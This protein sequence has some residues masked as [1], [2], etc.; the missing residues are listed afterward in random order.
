MGGK[1]QGELVPGW[2]A[3]GMQFAPGDR[4]AYCQSGI[5]ACGRVV[6]VV[7]GQPFEQF[8]QEKEMID[9]AVRKI[10]GE[11]EE[12]ALKKMMAKKATQQQVMVDEDD[13]SRLIWSLS[14]DGGFDDN[15]FV[16]GG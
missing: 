15:M 2:A 13:W 6:E 16:A 1:I 10:Q 9:Q 5:N 4:W 3:A 14:Q 12:A 11:N 7:S 8:L